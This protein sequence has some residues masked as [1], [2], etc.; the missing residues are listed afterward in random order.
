MEKTNLQRFIALKVGDRFRW[1]G[2]LCRVVGTGGPIALKGIVLCVPELASSSTPFELNWREMDSIE[3]MPDPQELVGKQLV[4]PPIGS[5]PSAPRWPATEFD[6]L[7]AGTKFKL[8]TPYL[9]LD[10]VK[11][12][13]A[14]SRGMKSGA[15]MVSVFFTVDAVEVPGNDN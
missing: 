10:T 3:Y 2:N 11:L 9:R 13:M 15:R 4:P 1:G 5:D 6:Y 8:S 14:A 12:L 7:P